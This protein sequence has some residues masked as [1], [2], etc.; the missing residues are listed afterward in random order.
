MVDFSQ[1]NLNKLFGSLA[2]EDD[3]QNNLKNYFLKTSVYDRLINEDKVTIVQ[4]Y[5]GTGKSAMLK[6]AYDHFQ[7]K[8][9]LCLWLKPEEFPMVRMDNSG[10]T[11]NL[12][13]KWKEDL[14]NLI[15][16]K[17]YNNY[18]DSD[19][20]EKKIFNVVTAITDMFTIK[21]V[22]PVTVNNGAIKKQIA[23]VF[24][25]EKKI[26]V[27]IDDLDTLW[28]AS[29]ESRNKISSLISA[30]RSLSN[31][32]TGL[33]FRLSLRSDMYFLLRE[34]DSNLDKIEGN[35]VDIQWS[36]NELWIVLIRRVQF[37]LNGCIFE[38]NLLH[39]TQDELDVYLK[40]IMNLTFEGK[41]RWHNRPIHQI[42]L[43]LIR[44]R[45]RDLINLCLSGATEARKQGHQIIETADWEN[46]FR[47]YSIERFK[48]T[49]TEHQLEFH[50]EGVSDLLNAMKTTKIEAH[51]NKN[52]FTYDELFKKTSNVLSQKHITNNSTNII[53]TTEV[54]MEFL[55]RIGFVVARKQDGT[56]FI[57]R[58]NYI[59]DPDLI[60]QKKGYE[61]EIHP[62]FRWALNYDSNNEGDFIDEHY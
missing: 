51:N 3:D 16:E 49:I 46:V 41:G 57:E 50:G 62:A 31:D 17:A 23:Q 45:P 2:A 59:D 30:I 13:A 44:E 33:N 5:K 36:Q 25:R 11:S 7:Q 27:F 43:S 18:F 9:I 6:M 37:F 19:K 21:D 35:I 1:I 24:L 48:D 53:I 42:L 61:F 60:K 32:D 26:F 39:K 58:R 20:P 34:S 28:D 14:R 56:G 10:N 52:K 12:I 55:Y 40:D 47:P 4:G 54:A 8:G 29:K 15:V 22:G 38:E